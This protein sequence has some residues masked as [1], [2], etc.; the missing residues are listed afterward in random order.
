MG[1]PKCKRRRLA[2]PRPAP[3]IARGLDVG[4]TVTHKGGRVGEDV[5]ARIYT[6]RPR[7]VWGPGSPRRTSVELLMPPP[8]AQGRI[9]TVSSVGAP[10]RPT[11]AGARGQER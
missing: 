8:A 1:K 10:P 7:L 6:T 9:Q 4:L 3:G 5:G 2:G 11:V